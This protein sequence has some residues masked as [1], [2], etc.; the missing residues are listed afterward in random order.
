MQFQL[1]IT[2]EIGKDGRDGG[3]PQPTGFNLKE[4]EC[5]HESI[6]FVFSGN[7]NKTFVT[8]YCILYAKQYSN[9]DKLKNKNKNTNFKI[10]VPPQIYIKMEQMLCIKNNQKLKFDKFIIIYENM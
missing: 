9:L 5:I 7:S 2:S 4:E 8:N 10:F 3:T 1:N 6:L